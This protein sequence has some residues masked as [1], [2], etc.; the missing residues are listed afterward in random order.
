MGES[1]V[2]GRLVSIL[3]DWVIMELLAGQR[4]GLLID[5][6]DERPAGRPPQVP[7]H[8]PDIYSKSSK[9]FEVILG[10]AKTAEDLLTR[11]TEGQISEFLQHCSAHKSSLF[12]LAVP[13]YSTKLATRMLR[14][15]Q[16]RNGTEAVTTKILEKLPG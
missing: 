11:H 13:W 14:R 2:H 3:S 15:I 5:D 7:N 10:E 16:K 12:V 1:K 8:R 9:T 6:V 4:N